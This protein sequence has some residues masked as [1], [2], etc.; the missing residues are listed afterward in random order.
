MVHPLT[1]NGTE[2]GVQEFQD[3]LFLIYCLDPPD[4]TRLCDG[5][6]AAF[7][8]CHSLDCKKGG[9]V[10]ARHNELCDRVAD[11]AGKYFTPTHVRNSPLIFAGRAMQMP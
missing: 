1:V 8:I 9:L 11:L 2:L 3:A 6:N 4:I 5:C 10:T 7:S